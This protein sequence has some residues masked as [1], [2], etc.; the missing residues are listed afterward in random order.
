[1][2]EQNPWW[3]KEPDPTLVRW[4]ES[5]L[6]WMPSIISEIGLEPFSLHFLFGPRQVG[7]TTALKLLIEREIDRGRDPRS[8]FYRSC[9]LLTDHMELDKTLDD[10]LRARKAWG[11]GPSLIILDEITFVH[12]WWRAVKSKIDSGVFDRDVL[13][14]T[15]SSS[16]DLLKQKELFPG[17]RG[18]GRDLLMR[19]LSFS[20]YLKAVHGLKVMSGP[21]SE[22]EKNMDG[23]LLISNRSRELLETYLITGGF[24]LSIKD[25]IE[26]KVVSEET[27]DTYL[28][29]LRGDW[30]KAGK[31]DVYMKEVVRYLI[32]ARGTP[33]SWNGLSSETSINS[34]HTA[35]SYVETLQGIYS[36]LVLQLL[37]PDRRVLPRKNR[38]VHFTDPFIYRILSRYTGEKMDDGWLAEGTAASHLSRWGDAFYWRNGSEVDVVMDLSG[39]QT[40][41]EITWGIKSWKRPR[42]IP[43]TFM[44]DRENYHL[45][46]SSIG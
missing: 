41:F 1:M 18:K 37:S 14:I 44:V 32:R 23:N 42:H 6:R 20:E 34:P 38:K 5:K 16:M 36:A 7:K 33:I 22:L 11:T 28:N 3:S 30:N 40:G 29:W 46:L 10:Y 39:Q 8:I 26:R 25:I 27:M 4:R 2:E 19:P 31:S 35:R 21:F 15:G 45:F 24:P 12:D 17:R 9:D 13:I 43:R